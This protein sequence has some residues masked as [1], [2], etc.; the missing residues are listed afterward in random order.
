MGIPQGEHYTMLGYQMGK[1]SLHRGSWSKSGKPRTYGWV[2]G[3]D[4]PRPIVCR[5][6]SSRKR[7]KKK[8]SDTLALLHTK[9]RALEVDDQ[10]WKIQT[11]KELREPDVCEWGSSSRQSFD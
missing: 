9:S 8:A 6:E 7:R 2:R 5:E 4:Q 1:K 3:E 10:P 11:C